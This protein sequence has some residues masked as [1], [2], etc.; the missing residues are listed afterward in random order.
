MAVRDIVLSLA[1]RI[2]IAEPGFVDDVAAIQFDDMVLNFH[3]EE[4]TGEM[5]L[6]MDVGAAPVAADERLAAYS[7]LLKA[8]CFARQT[9]GGVLGVDDEENRVIFS[10]SFAAGAMDAAQLERV[11]ETFLNL[12]ETFR[13][14]LADVVQASSVTADVPTGGLRA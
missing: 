3:V 10:H 5:E 1:Q 12:A 8:N 2:G 4:K 14:A 13:D 9:G 6:F 11:V 7:R